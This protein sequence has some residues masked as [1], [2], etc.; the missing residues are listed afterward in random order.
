MKMFMIRV[1]SSWLALSIKISPKSRSSE[2]S[3]FLKCGL[4]VRRAEPHARHCDLCM[5]R[6]LIEPLRAMVAPHSI[7]AGLT[8]T[9]SPGDAGRLST[10]Q[11][12]DTKILARVEPS[13]T[14]ACYMYPGT[15]KS[16]KTAHKYELVP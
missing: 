15:Q 10:S 16:A 8:S 4:L 14:T 7:A 9:P 11:R 2:Q 13:K 12:H 3:S 5:R 6:H 1:L